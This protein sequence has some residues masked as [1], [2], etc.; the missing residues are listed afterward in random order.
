[1]ARFIGGNGAPFSTSNCFRTFF[2]IAPKVNLL[3][4]RVLDQNGQAD[5][6]T[7][8]SGLQ[9]IIQNKNTH[10]IRVIN[11]SLGP[12]SDRSSPPAPCARPSK[13]LTTPASSPAPPET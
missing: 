5:I 4:V 10:T 3:C 6:S 7:V 8:I 1:M 13:P 9:W 11:L 2:G 12:L